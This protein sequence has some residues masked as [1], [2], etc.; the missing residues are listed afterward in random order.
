MGEDLGN[1]KVLLYLDC[2]FK[3]EDL[4]IVEDADWFFDKCLKDNTRNVIFEAYLKGIG[5]VV[6]KETLERFDAGF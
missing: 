6:K 2:D 3:K 4:K 5:F 1:G